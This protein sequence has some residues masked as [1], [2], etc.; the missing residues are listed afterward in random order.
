MILGN[1]ALTGVA[2]LPMHLPVILIAF[3]FGPRWGVVCGLLSPIISFLVGGMP[4]VTI[5]PYIVLELSAYGVVGGF[6]GQKQLPSLVKLFITQI[7][8]RLIRG[9]AVFGALFLFNVK[10]MSA[11]SNLLL[12]TKSALPGIMLQWVLIPLLISCVEK[13]KI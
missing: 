13:R 12:M 9:V 7:S 11:T 10:A 8:G 6:V 3:V 2:F 4:V 1:G 5:L